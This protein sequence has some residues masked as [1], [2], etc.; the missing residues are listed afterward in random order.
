[1]TKFSKTTPARPKSPV[2]TVSARPDT[3]THGG[4]PAYSRDA[5]SDLYLL[6]VTNLVGEA[7]F[8]ESAETRDARF[9]GLVHQVT[10]EDPEWMQGFIPWLRVGANMRSAS[11]VAAI[12]YVRAGGPNGRQ[13]VDSSLQRPDEPAEAVGYWLS[14]YGRSIPKPIRR[15]IGDAVRR[16]YN[17]RS[18][19]KYDSQRNTMRMGDV[20]EIVHPPNKAGWQAALYEHIL[21]DRH[22][23]GTE[24]ADRHVADHLDLLRLDDLMLSVPMDRRRQLL[25]DVPEALKAAGWTWERLSGWLPG[26]MDAEAWEAIIP[27]MGVMALLRNLRNFDEKRISEVARKQVVDTITD[28]GAVKRSRIFPFRVWA[29]Y[30]SVPSDYWGHHLGTTLDLASLNTPALER[31]LVAIDTSSSMRHPVS[32]R[33]TMS[34]VEVAALM[35]ATMVTRSNADV[36]IFGTTSA[37]VELPKGVS[38]LKA[39][40]YIVNLVGEVGH[41]TRGHTAIQHW[42]DKA[43]HQRVVMFTDDQMTDGR[44]IDLSHVPVIYTFNLAG[45]S[46][47]ALPSGAGS[48]YSLGGFNDASYGLLKALEAGRSGVWPW[49]EPG[50]GA[51]APVAVEEDDG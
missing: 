27:S 10:A 17:E 21:N 38:T 44:M 35:A 28:P 12:E 26:G 5:K 4:T 7:T 46:P 22:H 37:K 18:F 15:G 24:K 8:Y 33:S 20:L 25:S 47:S 51:K 39:V 3:R 16:L 29:A 23:S 49:L 50:Y 30:R 32:G 48:R 19:L 9:E 2:R 40:A 42:Y 36:V 13:V 34:R 45:Y 6:A 31:T 11:L 14:R 1:M 41:E 43:K